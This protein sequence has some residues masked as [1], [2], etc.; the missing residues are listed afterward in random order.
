MDF[1]D[2]QIEPPRS[3]EKFEDI[4]R[5]LFAAVYQNPLAEKNGRRGQPQRGVDIYV[6]PADT[7]GEW[8]G[9]QCK[10]KERNYNS[11]PTKE[12]F[13]KELSKAELFTPSLNRWIFATTAPR[14]ET[15]QAHVRNV[16][17]ARQ[18]SGKFPVDILSWDVLQEMIGAQPDVLRTFYPEHF[19]TTFDAAKTL[20]RVASE[21]LDAI[22]DTLH[23]AD[24]SIVLPREKLQVAAR[25]ALSHYG[26]IRLTGE[27]GTGK[28]GLLKRIALATDAPKLVFKDNRV[29]AA[30]FAEHLGQLGIHEAAGSVL[31]AF[32]GQGEA[33][34]VIDGADRLLMSGRRE[35]VLDVF[36]AI[37][38]CGT[39]EQWR[40]V[41]SA[42]NYQDRDL[43]ADA[44]REAGFDQLGSQ[45][46]VGALSADEIAQ[47]AKQFPQFAPLLARP[48]LENY[49]RSL[50]MLRDLFSRRTPPAQVPSEVDAADS[51]ITG[52]GLT[53]TELAHRG[54]ALAQI[55]TRLVTTP[56]DLPG[57]RS[58]SG[59]S[60]SPAPRG[61]DLA[62]TR[63]GRIPSRARCPRRLAPRETP[64]FTPQQ[65][66]RGSP[67]G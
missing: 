57:R 45:I 14:D 41:T 38:M 37:R 30:T 64:S 49:T 54:K 8:I 12:E 31:D 65:T 10:G 27:G 23:R 48:D 16:S 47:I 9:I 22:E 36:R 18:A 59:R 34:C 17:K 26:I 53:V 6:E 19:H 39:R 50:F 62:T 43:V 32:A 61:G 44:L 29:T 56:W 28:S 2:K 4:S 3:W 13:D 24:V 5:A 15:L 11:K 33:L 21:A 7:P 25:E 35:L 66:I 46:V 52:N 60:P 67:I 40:I 58:S 1:F 20:R 55:G 51:W 42:R 63:T